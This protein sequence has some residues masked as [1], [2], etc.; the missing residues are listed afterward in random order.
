MEKYWLLTKTLPNKDNQE[1]VGDFILHLKISNRS[2][3]TIIL[4]RKFLE[5]FFGDV[6]DTYSTLPPDRILEWFQTNNKHLKET[7]YR[8]NLDIISSFYNF[9]I[10]ESLLDRSPIKRRWFPRIPKSLPKYIEKGDIAKIRLESE[11][12]LRSQALVEF[13][14]TSGCRV[15]EVHELNLEDIDMENRT[16]RVVGKGKKIRHVHFSNKCAVLLERYVESRNCK[17]SSPLFVGLKS[18]TRLSIRGIQRTMQRIGE[19]A[20]LSTRLHPHRLRHTFATELLAKGAELS[21][22]SD[23][24]GHAD[25]DTTQIYARLPKQ[26]IVRQYRKYMG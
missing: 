16:A 4:Y 13:M 12:S 3:G 10:Q 1:V 6:E 24:L 20:A 26:E 8:L 19:N 2:K 7:S 23:E 21:F 25:L 9:C 15:A 5:R 17:T 18:E 22:I 11:K 14:L